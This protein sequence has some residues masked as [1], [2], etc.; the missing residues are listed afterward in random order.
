MNP[1]IA[2]VEAAPEQEG[3][4]PQKPIHQQVYLKSNKTL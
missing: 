2:L 1:V 3:D 4:I